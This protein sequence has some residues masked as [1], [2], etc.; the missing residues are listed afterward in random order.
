MTAQFIRNGNEW[1]PVV[2][3]PIVKAVWQRGVRLAQRLEMAG[4]PNP[5][6]IG[7]L[8]HPLFI[9]RPHPI[10]V[11]SGRLAEDV[12]DYRAAFESCWQIA[13]RNQR[14]SGP[15]RKCLRF[16]VIA[17]TAQDGCA[18]AV[19]SAVQDR[20][21]ALSLCT[22]ELVSLVQDDRLNAAGFY[23]PEEC[24]GAGMADHL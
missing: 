7:K 5:S 22:D 10:D 21:G 8:P 11:L 13:N 16:M 20:Q 24:R 9:G 4:R 15:G 2:A 3:I 6:T 1:E 14:D 17:V 19:M 12:D 23:Q 18:R